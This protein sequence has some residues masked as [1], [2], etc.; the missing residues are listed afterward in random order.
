LE[1]G[2][3]DRSIL[4]RLNLLCAFF[5]LGQIA[6][7][8]LLVVALYSPRITDRDGSRVN[9]AEESQTVSLNLWN[10]NASVFYLGVL[11][12]IVFFLVTCT[13]KVIREVNLQGAVRYLWFLAWLLPLQIFFI[14]TLF[15]Y[16]KGATCCDGLGVHLKALSNKSANRIK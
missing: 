3:S 1:V 9:R 11:G 2:A 15:D 10:L 8:A 5:A 12:F 14:I 4:Y 6:A 7:A 13:L 16:H